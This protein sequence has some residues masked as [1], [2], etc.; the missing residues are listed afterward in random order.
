MQETPVQ[1]LSQKDPLE[2]GQA[3]H[4]SILWL[5]LCLSWLSIPLQCGRPWFD[6]WVGKIPSRRARLPTPVF[7][8]REF[9]GLYSP[10]GHKESDTTEQLS[11][12]RCFQQ[13]LYQFTFPPKMY[14]SSVLSTCLPAFVISYLVDTNYP[15]IQYKV[16][17]H[18]GFHLHFHDVEHIL[19]Y[20]MAICAYVFFEEIS[21]QIFFPL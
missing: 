20:L 15:N 13:Q 14:N 4:S 12:S 17:S 8:P 3:T 10:C 7:W 1:F 21:I 2:K 18:C 19:I 16:A 9:H 11:L 6:P 5:P